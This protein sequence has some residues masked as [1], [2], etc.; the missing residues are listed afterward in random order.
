[1]FRRTFV[2]GY[3]FC[4]KPSKDAKFLTSTMNKDHD[5][6][7]IRHAESLFNQA[8]EQYRLAHRIPYVWK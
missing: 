8:C 1:M 4:A 5:L 3:K 7:F 6:V 2:T